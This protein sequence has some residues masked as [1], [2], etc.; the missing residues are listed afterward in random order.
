VGDLKNAVKTQELAVKQSPYY[1]QIHR[2]LRFFKEELAKQKAG[3][4]SRP[5]DESADEPNS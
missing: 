1:Q 3:Q 2:Q 5:P 4:E